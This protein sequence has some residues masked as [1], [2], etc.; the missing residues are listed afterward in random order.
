MY[1]TQLELTDFR[2]HRSLT[3]KPG[4]EL[5]VLVG[6][7]AAGKTNVIEAIELI[8]AG[9]SF[10][11]P[12]WTELVAWDSDTARVS[13]ESTGETPGVRVDVTVHKTGTRTWRVDGVTRNRGSDTTGVV[14][15][16]MFTPDDLTLVKGPAERRR[17]AIDLLGDQ[18][19]KTYGTLRR[20]YSRV[21]RQRNAVLKGDVDPR[22]LAA[23]TEQMATLG[24][25]LHVHRRR[26][27]VRVMVAA[28]RVY[29]E[30]ADGE[31]LEMSMCDRCGLPQLQPGEEVAQQDAIR[32][33]REE[34]TRR[35]GDEASR[36]VS[37]AGPHRDDIRFLIGGHDA[38]VFASQGQQRTLSLAW[39]WAEVTVIKEV[40]DRRPVLL[41][42]DVMS[43]LD[44]ARR[45]ALSELIQQDI[46]TFITTTNTGYFDTTLLDKAHVVPIGVGQ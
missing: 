29:E 6:P 27:A 26:L 40:L 32:S 22:L 37:L 20:E 17:A 11:N 30:L 10:R 36:R 16:V 9:R 42:D 33:L 41:L 4:R 19:S 3:I 8:A 13:M 43:E 21:L 39:K 28:K 44:A 38:R 34:L 14:P 1:I 31:Q 12:R 35:A 15:I 46:Q 18:L 24:G 5:T 7:N 45:R 25:K 23:L 2:S